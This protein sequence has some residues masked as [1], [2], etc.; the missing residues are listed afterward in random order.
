MQTMMKFSGSFFGFLAMI[1]V[2]VLG[3]GLHSNFSGGHSRTITATVEETIVMLVLAFVY[4]MS[5][6]ATRKEVPAARFWG[7]AASLATLAMPLMLMFRFHHR[8][9]NA[10]WIVVVLTLV[11]LISYTWPRDGSRQ[12]ESGPSTNS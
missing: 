10:T 7:I 12:D 3:F 6:W 4:A 8:L 2:G 5:W 9:N 11:A 1:C